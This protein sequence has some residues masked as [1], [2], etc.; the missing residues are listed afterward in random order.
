MTDKLRIE[1]ILRLV[2]WN[3]FYHLPPLLLGTQ[4]TRKMILDLVV[5]QKFKWFGLWMHVLE[6]GGLPL[7]NS[8]YVQ[9]PKTGILASFCPLFL[10]GIGRSHH[11][12]CAE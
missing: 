7:L 10:E 12:S 4:F 9:S 8:V 3:L 2:C 5:E 1:I 11:Q 6:R